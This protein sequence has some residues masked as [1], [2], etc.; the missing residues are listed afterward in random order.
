ME[1]TCVNE[2]KWN[3]K[4]CECLPGFGGDR[5]QDKVPV[6]QNGGS[7]DGIKCVCTNLY[8]GLNCEEVV[9][10]IELNPPET[11]SA[12]VELTVTVTSE[13][14]TKE[15]QN[16]SSPQ[17]RKFNETFTKQ[18]D[19]VYSG[20]PEYQG[21]NITRLT[22]GSVVVEHDVILK[23][24]FTPGYK[25]AFKKV[26][27]EVEE[28]VMTVTQ[29]QI[30]RNYTCKDLLCFNTTATKVQNISVT[31][32]DP[33][34]ECR[35]K[36]GKDFA[37][38]FF[39]EYKNQTPNCI[40][41]CMPGFNTSMNCNFGKCILER[42]GPRC[43]CLATDTDWYSGENCEFST[44]KSLVYGILGTV[45]AVMLV[46]LI[47]LLVFVFLSKRE[48][49]RQ[50]SKVTQLYKWHEE[51]GGPAP[52]TFQNIGFDIQQEDLK[53]L[54]YIYNNFQPSLDHIDSNTKIKIQRPQVLM[55]SI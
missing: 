16:W 6:C 35:E 11:V 9:S 37:E 15:L 8:Q 46:A 33:E 26:I 45:G 28:R 31:Q 23:A 20:I 2:G 18:M 40:T 30:M 22:S 13:N 51:N 47:T 34:E 50:K 36:A 19:I 49:K 17:F 1:V 4:T 52:G 55:T 44:K 32:Y 42:S 53:Q 27:K 10:S 3:G 7:W 12:Q 38:Y 54:D 24:A 29:V 43:Y 41:R 39:V 14:F 48:V 5:C 25:E 21:V